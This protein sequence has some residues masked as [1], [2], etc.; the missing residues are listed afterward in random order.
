MRQR[1]ERSF[2]GG[3]GGGVSSSI[4]SSSVSAIR[5]AWWSQHLRPYVGKL[6][7]LDAVG[8]G[9]MR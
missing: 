3:G 9:Q 7:V 4:S 6:L 2:G 1:Y 5:G 8:S